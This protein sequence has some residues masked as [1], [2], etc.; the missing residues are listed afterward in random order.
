M[1]TWVS[2]MLAIFIL[3]PLWLVVSVVRNAGKR[4]GQI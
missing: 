4:R 2:V 1:P 3:F